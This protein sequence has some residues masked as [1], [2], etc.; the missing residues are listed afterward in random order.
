MVARGLRVGVSEVFRDGV[1]RRAA[2]PE[3]R[4]VLGPGPPDRRL[5]RD[6][7]AL[8]RGLERPAERGERER[9]PGLFAPAGLVRSAITHDA[10][11]RR[12][13]LEVCRET[14]KPQAER[15]RQAAANRLL[16]DLAPATLPP[17]AA[18]DA[19]DAVFQVHVA[20][21]EAPD[22]SFADSGMQPDL[23]RRAREGAD[24][25]FAE[26]S[27]ELV[28]LERLRLARR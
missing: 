2:V 15:L 18:A 6:A 24:R 13:G 20:D 5:L 16:Y 11:Q 8:T 10:E 25:E 17:L 12:L 9:V 7:R 1:D 23:E 14:A 28:G 21:L 19:E 4:R 3:E 27:A 22:L 26:E